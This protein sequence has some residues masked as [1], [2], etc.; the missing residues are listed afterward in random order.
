VQFWGISDHSN[1]FNK[2]SA[3]I[4]ENINTSLQEMMGAASIMVH[5]EML[6]S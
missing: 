3:N 4:T 6:E 2:V 5:T 1:Y